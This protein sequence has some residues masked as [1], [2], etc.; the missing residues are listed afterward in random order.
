MLEEQ[1]LSNSNA[2]RTLV[3]SSVRSAISN[4]SPDLDS[5][6]PFKTDIVKWLSPVID[7]S[8]F[9][10]YPMNGITQGLDWWMAKEHRNIYMDD[11]DYQWVIPSSNMYD[12]P[13]KYIS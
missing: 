7:L 9:H 5:V 8:N 13:I 3:H 2:V 1:I 12:S 10:V 11:G 6:T 4:I